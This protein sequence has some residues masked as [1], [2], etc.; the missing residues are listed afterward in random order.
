[1]A[2]IDWNYFLKQ[3]KDVPGLAGRQAQS[4]ATRRAHEYLSVGK[5]LDEWGARIQLEAAD[6]GARVE[7]RQRK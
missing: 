5:P 1:M 6:L 4:R 7:G 2:C 3:E